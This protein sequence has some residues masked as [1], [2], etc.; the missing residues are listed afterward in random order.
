M[1]HLLRARHSAKY[2]PFILLRVPQSA[3]KNQTVVER[4]ERRKLRREAK[5]LAESHID[6]NVGQSRKQRPEVDR[7]G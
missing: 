5:W 7:G 3:L 2:F 6:R 1:K 4:L